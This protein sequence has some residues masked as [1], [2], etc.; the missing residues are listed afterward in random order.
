M[1]NSAHA[2][3]LDPALYE[4]AHMALMAG[5]QQEQSLA[6]NAAINGLQ[7]HDL[8]QQNSAAL[9]NRVDTKYVLPLS[10]FEELLAALAQEYTVLTQQGTR[11]FS[12]E[13]TYFDTVHQQF[14]LAHHNGKLNR[15]KVRF[16]RY[17]QSNRGFMEVK[18]KNNKR[19]T[20]KKRVAMDCQM[21]DQNKVNG[22]VKDC[23]GETAASLQASLFVNYRRITLLNKNRP[24]RLTIDLDLSFQCANTGQSNML[25]DVFIVELKREGKLQKSSFSHWL[26]H[27][28]IKPIKFSK[29]CMGMVLT[30]DRHL[31]QNR[32][33]PT[34]SQLSKITGAAPWN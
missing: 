13:T 4:A 32:F 18:L 17:V 21:P 8:W 10:V 26:S 29:Y 1:P 15:H 24:E 31:K 5:K 30:H 12:Y 28:N 23:I 27:N 16:R 25:D 20:I 22:F 14:Y 3:W 34:I 33:K 6:V 19:R 2:Q 9:M 7:P 11:I